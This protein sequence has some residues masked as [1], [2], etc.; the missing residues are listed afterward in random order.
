MLHVRKTLLIY[1]LCLLLVMLL[2]VFFGSLVNIWVTLILYLVTFI[3]L[4]LQTYYFRVY[5]NKELVFFDRFL[6]VFAWL[7]SFFCV[8]LL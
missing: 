4:I 2:E 1:D 7:L 6:L 3:F 8:I 5:S